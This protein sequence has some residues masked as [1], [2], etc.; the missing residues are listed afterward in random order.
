MPELLHH[1]LCPHSRFVRLALHEYEFEV[2]LVGERVWNRREQFLA[3]NPAGTIPVLLAEGRPPIPGA[4][5]IAE[6]LD[7]TLGPRFGDRRL[8]PLQL[9]SRIEVRRLMAWF[10]N[11][12][13][14]EVSGPL[15]TERYKQ[16]MPVQA[17]GGSPDYAAVRA[18]R[19]N[20]PDHLAYIDD[21]LSGREWLAGDRLS[22]ADLAAAAHLSIIDNLVGV[23]WPEA[24]TACNWFTR[25][26]ARPSFITM[27]RDG[28]KG[29]V[30]I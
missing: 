6:Y 20:I 10:N 24:E 21:L 29:F 23:P 9:D 22:Y 18:A 30:R 17:G 14:V 7:E 28:W 19:D 1:P 25:M 26:Q 2:E 8:L 11:K 3:L 16:F 4:S 27:L 13:F 5:I 12:F 15:T